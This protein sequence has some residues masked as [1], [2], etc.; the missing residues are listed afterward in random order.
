MRPGVSTRDDVCITPFPVEPGCGAASVAAVDLARCA[1]AK[2][3]VH[4][5]TRALACRGIRGVN[6]F[7]ACMGVRI[8]S[9]KTRAGARLSEAMLAQAVSAKAL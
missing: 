2:L 4:A 9:H 6:A 1:L 3:V 8:K 7:R 5:S